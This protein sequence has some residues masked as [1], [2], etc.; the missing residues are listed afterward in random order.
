MG[1]NSKGGK[2]DDVNSQVYE[3][4]EFTIT[5]ASGE[6]EAFTTIATKTKR[7]WIRVVNKGPGRILV[8]PQGQPKETLFKNQGKYWNHS[9]D[10]EIYVEL[11]TGSTA[12]VFVEE[13]G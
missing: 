9:D 3:T 1:L 2:R 5:S 4:R 13:S 10:L 7:Q 8:G 12:V 11:A 6:V